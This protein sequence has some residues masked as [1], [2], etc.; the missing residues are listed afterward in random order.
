MN[1]HVGRENPERA[2]GQ[3][4]G[5]VGMPTCSSAAHRLKATAEAV[6]EVGIGVPGR[7]QGA[8]IGDCRQSEDTRSTLPGAFSSQKAEDPSRFGEAA[9]RYPEH[10]NNTHSR[11]RSHTSECTARVRGAT[12]VAPHPGSSIAAHQVRLGCVGRRRLDDVAQRRAPIDLHHSR[13][14]HVTADGHQTRARLLR[15]AARLEAVRSIPGDERDVGQRLGV[16]NRPGIRGDSI[17]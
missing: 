6:H 15:E 12:P 2:L 14:G 3:P 17:L 7:E 9:G 16:V 5:S 11:R 13:V 1:G 10:D 8:V 4:Y